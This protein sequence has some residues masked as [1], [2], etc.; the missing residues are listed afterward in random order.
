MKLTILLTATVK[1]Q[2]IGGNFTMDERALMYNASTL[3]FCAN[4]FGKRYLKQ[5]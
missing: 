2:V 4:T 3:R 5:L 1:I